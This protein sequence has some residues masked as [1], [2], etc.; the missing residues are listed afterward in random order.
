MTKMLSTRSSLMQHF[1]FDDLYNSNSD[2]R[3]GIMTL[4]YRFKFLIRPVGILYI[5]NCL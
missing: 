5:Q 4:D 2:K 1:E 3:Q